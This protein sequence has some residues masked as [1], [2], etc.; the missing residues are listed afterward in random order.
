MKNKF[1]G[2]ILGLSGGIDSA[3]CAAISADALGSEKVKCFMLPFK[4]TSKQSFIDAIECAKNLDIELGSLDIGESFNSLES[5]LIPFFDNLP[6]DVTEENLQSR[7]R[8]T[9]PSTIGFDSACTT[10][11]ALLFGNKFEATVSKVLVSSWK[12]A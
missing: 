9:A 3:L 2:V 12:L 8:G 10:S 4:Y 11:E 7:I 6:K 5:V 1:P